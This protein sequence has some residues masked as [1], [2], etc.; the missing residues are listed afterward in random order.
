MRTAD[1]LMNRTFSLSIIGCVLVSCLLF[2]SGCTTRKAKTDASEDANKKVHG[3]TRE[4]AAEVLVKVGDTTITVGEFAERL[5]EQSPYLRARYNSAERRREFLE[6]LVRFELLAAEARRRGYTKSP[7]VE[8]TRKQVMIQQ[9]M[10]ADFEEGIRLSDVTEE[11]IRAYYD[12]NPS[13]FNKPEQVRA[14]HILFHDRATA[15]RVLQQI[16]RASRPATRA[17][18][19]DND[20]AIDEARAEARASG[21]SEQAAVAAI[22]ARESDATGEDTFRQAAAQYNEDQETKDRFG[23]LRFFSRP[24]QRTE[25]EPTVPPEVAN[26]AFSIQD[27]GT[28]HPELVRSAQGFHIVKLTG[29]RAALRRS[30]DE[31]RRSIQNQLWREKREKAVEDLVTKLRREARVEEHLELLSEVRVNL[32]E[33]GTVPAIPGTVPESPGPAR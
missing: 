23:D 21:E 26:A 33:P 5:A 30:L 3:L 17:P 25:G 2:V 32:P 20:E 31:V 27:V 9:M 29:R 8:R 13:E 28:V 18:Q 15:Q 24:D 22:E 10:K 12:A 11:Q 7:E 14:S 19:H 4:Q 1:T 6:N 16:L